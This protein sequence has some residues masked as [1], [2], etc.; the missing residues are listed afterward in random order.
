MVMVKLKLYKGFSDLL[1]MLI[2]FKHNAF[3][4]IGGG[5]VLP[6]SGVAG[7]VTCV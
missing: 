5:E 7:Y 4:C 1:N 3:Y 2:F 6:I